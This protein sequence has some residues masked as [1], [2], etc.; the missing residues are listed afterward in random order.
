MFD[1]IHYWNSIAAKI[2][3]TRKWDE[4]NP[5]SQHLIIQ[6]INSLIQAINTK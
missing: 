1:V 3:D 6:S 2:G 5:H 4:L